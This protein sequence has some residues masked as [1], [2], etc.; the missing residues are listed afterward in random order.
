MKRI[1]RE[2]TLSVRFLLQRF[3]IYTCNVLCVISNKIQNSYNMQLLCLVYHYCYT[4]AH[5]QR[6]YQSVIMG[7]ISNV[8]KFIIRNVQVFENKVRHVFCDVGTQQTKLF[9]HIFFSLFVHN[10]Y[11]F[12]FIS[13]KI[14]YEYIIKSSYA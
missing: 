4:L 14:I 7:S 13:L 9:L 10:K 12:F 11:V 5:G 2:P 6:N 1:R 8:T 3:S